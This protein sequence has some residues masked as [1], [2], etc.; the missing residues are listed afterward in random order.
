MDDS[1]GCSYGQL[2]IGS[3]ITTHAEFLGKTSNPPGDSAPHSP[4]LVPW[5][6]RL[7]PKLKSPVKGKRFQTIDEIQENTM[8][9][10]LAIGRTVRGPKVSTLKGTEVS[11]SMYNVS[12][13]LHYLR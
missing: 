5:D 6:S 12:G 13:I 9:Q 8:G 1:E 11:L 7:F 2:V 4:D 10:L 3:F